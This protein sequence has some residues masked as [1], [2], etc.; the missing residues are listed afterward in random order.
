MPE[1]V[2]TSLDIYAFDGCC[3]VAEVMRGD[4]NGR[5]LEGL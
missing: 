1:W 2:K 5:M 3:N 4:A